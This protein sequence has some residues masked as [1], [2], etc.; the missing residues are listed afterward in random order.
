MKLSTRQTTHQYST[1]IGAKMTV[2]K[3]DDNFTYSFK[4]DGKDIEAKDL[5]QN[6]VLNIAYDTTGSFRESSFYDVIVT[7]NVVDGVKCTSRNDSKGEYTI[8]GTK[9]KAAENIAY[10][11]I[12]SAE[13]LRLT[14]TQY[15][16]TTA[17]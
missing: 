9:Y 1:G 3:D 2:N 13:S 7:R 15:Q 4:L 11:L 16:R 10:T 17:Y 8:G 6:D 5:Q 12:T 14:K